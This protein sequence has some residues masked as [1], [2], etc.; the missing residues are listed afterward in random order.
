MARRSV[1]AECDWGDRFDDRPNRDEMIWITTF[2]TWTVG[3]DI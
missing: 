1:A 2:P 3:N